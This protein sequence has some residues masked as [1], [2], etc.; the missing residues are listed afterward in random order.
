MSNLKAHYSATDIESRIVASLRAAGLDPDVRLSPEQLAPL[1]HFHT[2]GL[3]ASRELIELARV[4]ADQRVL[5]VGAGLGGAARLLASAVGCRVDCIEMS[6]DYCAGATLLN[7]LTGLESRVTVHE[8]SALDLP[9]A[10]DSFDVVWMQNVGMN[11][12]DKRKLYGE[13][14]RVLQPGG[15]YAFQEMAAGSA[16][17]SYFPLPWATDPSQSFLVSADQMRSEL[18]D[19]GFATELLEDTSEE[20]LG[21]SHANATPSPAGQLGLA[22]FVEDL[23]QKGGNA[24]RSLEQGQIR[25]VRGVFRAG[26]HDG[27]AR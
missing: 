25:L 7:R 6:S 18:E 10:D 11:I 8:G 4:R 16:P 26:P 2:G 5:D 12:E 17:T 24:R 1:D 9:F 20:H 21:R 19:C 22:V 14:A 27:A 23:G 13:I 3:R 15:R